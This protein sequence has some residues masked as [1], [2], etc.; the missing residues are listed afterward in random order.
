MCIGNFGYSWHRTV[1][2]NERSIHKKWSWVYCYVFI[3]K[4]SN[5]SGKSDN[6]SIY[7]CICIYIHSDYP[8][9]GF[10]KLICEHSFSSSSNRRMS[11]KD[12]RGMIYSK[13]RLINTFFSILFSG[14]FKYEKCY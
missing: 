12:R 13:N 6:L 3:D 5:I 14:Y 8:V 9:K 4:S 7:L 1:R 2:F 11:E 10:V